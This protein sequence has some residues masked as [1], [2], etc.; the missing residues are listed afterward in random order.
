MP[1]IEKVVEPMNTSQLFGLVL[2]LV[3]FPSFAFLTPLHQ[4]VLGVI[5]L[6]SH[7]PGET[8]L[9]QQFPVNTLS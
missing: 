7:L 1:G 3:F 8:N 5:T 4:A 6:L 2:R 9:S